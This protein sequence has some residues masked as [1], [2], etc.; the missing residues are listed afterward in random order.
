MTEMQEIFRSLRVHSED[1]TPYLLGDRG[2]YFHV[3]MK[4]MPKFNCLL[5]VPR[6]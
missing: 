4:C 1:G 6:I 3:R 5:L 2:Q